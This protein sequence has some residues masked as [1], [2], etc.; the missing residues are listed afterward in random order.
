MLAW[1]YTCIYISLDIY[2]DIYQCKTWVFHTHKM[3]GKDM[4]VEVFHLMPCI[5]IRMR[6]PDVLLSSPSFD[7]RDCWVSAHFSHFFG[8]VS[9]TPVPMKRPSAI[10]NRGLQVHRCGACGSTEHRINTCPT[11]QAHLIRS[12]QKQVKDLKGKNS[13]RRKV[14]DR[15]EK[16]SRSSPKETRKTHV[17]KQRKAYRGSHG[18]ARTPCPA[19]VRRKKPQVDIFTEALNSEASA[20]AWLLS[21]GF[22]KR[23]RE[24]HRL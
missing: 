20:Q 14:V 2:V 8:S 21:N 10:R 12:L 9:S 6:Y 22:L 15:V 5:E 4:A 3:S 23:P 13:Q 19:E 11:K 18:V 16:K 1:M 7:I 24:M 17:L